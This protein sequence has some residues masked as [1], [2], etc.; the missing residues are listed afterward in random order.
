MIIYDSD[1]DPDY[2]PNQLHNEEQNIGNCDNDDI[3]NDNDENAQLTAD[4]F[5]LQLELL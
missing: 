3:E 5:E 2:F 4:E 1:I